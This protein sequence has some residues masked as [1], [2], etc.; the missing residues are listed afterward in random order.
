M[1]T[2]AR[3][4]RRPVAATVALTALAAS[5]VLVPPVRAATQG[6]DSPGG[7]AVFPRSEAGT[8]TVNGHGWGH[9][10]GMSQWGASVAAAEGVGY[11]E[12]LATY[13]PTATLAADPAP[14]R[15]R[16]WLESEA[17]TSTVL[18]ATRTATIT[19]VRAD[20][21]LARISTRPTAAATPAACAGRTVTLA[22]VRI[23]SD[24]PAIDVHCGRWRTVIP[25]SATRPGSS[26]SVVDSGGIV[27]VLTASGE[28][29]GYRGSIRM[30]PS[31][32][33]TRVVVK[34]GLEDYLR[35]VV[36][37][38]V[39]T[40]WAPDAMR[41]QAVAARTYARRSARDR[42]GSFFDV[43]G[44]TKSQA[45]PG[46]VRYDSSWRTTTRHE[47]A[48]SDAA[49][50]ATA[51][52]VLLVGGV[53]IR[54]EYTSSNGGVSAAG[55][56]PYLV[57]A[58]DPWDVRASANRY[59]SWTTTLRAVDLEARHPQLGRITGIRVDALEGIG[60]WGG[61]LSAVTLIGTGGTLA[62]RTGE[63]VRTGLGLRSTY[64]SFVGT[65]TPS[66]SA[67]PPGWVRP[68]PAGIADGT[69]FGVTGP[70]WS[71]GAHTGLDLR[72]PAGTP[73]LA[74]ADGQVSAIGTTGAYGLSVRI[75]HSDGRLT[76]YAHL[77]AILTTVGAHVVAGQ[78]VGRSGTTGNSTG[79]HLHLEVR[80]GGTC[81]D[82]GPYVSA[83]PAVVTPAPLR[84]PF[85]TRPTIAQGSRDASVLRLQEALAVSPATGYFGTLT[86]AA[87]VAAQ[88]TAGLPATGIVDVATWDAIAAADS[89]GAVS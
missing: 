69:A 27:A 78:Q 87:V 22:R 25:A 41:A 19:Y 66:P 45:Y 72:A 35:S 6:L 53:P 88:E 7:V 61:R 20:G 34:A 89:A 21:R 55:G 43:Y 38:E 5:L 75:T 57:A 82:P 85:D 30:T 26:M 9:G 71:S 46:T 54:A 56:T 12:I 39:G 68:V 24:R 4:P 18:R 51:G 73:V 8:W 10:R 50:A 1:P 15:I 76:L 52:Q 23:S 80:V 60:D 86:R 3:A 83:A 62:L 17:T 77:D 32:G 70:W 37:A 40:A 58:P 63:A 59:A 31:Q 13:Y 48:A 74:V 29:V 81:V 2:P 14:H 47:H 67:P 49:V 64:A 65:S 33:R 28:R 16:I 79:P 84:P 36:P 42:A 11:R 44:S